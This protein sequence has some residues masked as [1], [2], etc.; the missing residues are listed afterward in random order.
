MVKSWPVSFTKEGESESEPQFYIGI[1][2]CPKCKS[3]F[4]SR[5][6]TSEKSA[7]PASIATLVDRIKDV[8]QGLK[9]TLKTLREKVNALETERASLMIEI[10]ELKNG[11]ESRANSLENEVIQLREEVK[12]LRELLGSTDMDAAQ[13]DSP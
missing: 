12:S 11:A 4:R 8:R 9:E 3:R 10:R 13:P 7:E 6:E 1:F 5:M 2:E